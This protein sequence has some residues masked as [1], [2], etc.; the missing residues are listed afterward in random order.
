MLLGVWGRE[1]RGLG[2]KPVQAFLGTTES[3]PALGEGLGLEGVH[4][5]AAAQIGGSFLSGIHS[6]A[7]SEY[8][9]IFLD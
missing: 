5:L 7:V 8:I 1:N 9:S 3:V 6:L 4:S 2:G